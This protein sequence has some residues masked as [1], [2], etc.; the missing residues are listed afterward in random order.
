MRML[1]MGAAVT[2]LIGVPAAA[3]SLAYPAAV[4]R[5]AAS[6]SSALEAGCWFRRWCGPSRCH[7]AFVC[8]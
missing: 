4:S 2:V 3:A 7:R 6:I 5:A 1:V 8:R